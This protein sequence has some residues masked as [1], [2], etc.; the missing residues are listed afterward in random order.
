MTKIKTF[1]K[2]K[3]LESSDLE[4]KSIINSEKFQ[5]E[6]K[7]Y[8]DTFYPEFYKDEND[9]EIVYIWMEKK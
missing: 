8:G 2:I 4:L 9:G 6:L 5:K 3:K 7:E 1:P